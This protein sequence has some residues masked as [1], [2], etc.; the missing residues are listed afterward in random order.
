MLEDY[1]HKKKGRK[2]TMKKKKGENGD[3]LPLTA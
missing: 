3:K 1:R 2:K